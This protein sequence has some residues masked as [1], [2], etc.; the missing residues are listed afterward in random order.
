MASVSRLVLFSVEN[1]KRLMLPKTSFNVQC[2]AEYIGE[3][4]I[5]KAV[6]ACRCAYLWKRV[7]DYPVLYCATVC[8]EQNSTCRPP[9]PPANEIMAT[10]KMG[11]GMEIRNQHRFWGGEKLLD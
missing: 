9:Q 4:Y 2:E 1:P 6:C 11:S 7:I 5:S 8:F 3:T 10:Q